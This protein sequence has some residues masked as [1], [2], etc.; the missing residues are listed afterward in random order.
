M[1]IVIYHIYIYI[2]IY[3]Y[4]MKLFFEIDDSHLIVDNDAILTNSSLFKINE[5]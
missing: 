5:N 3:V 1:H 4:I 2:Y